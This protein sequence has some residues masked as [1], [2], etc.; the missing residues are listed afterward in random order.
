[1]LK[2]EETGEPSGEYE[3]TFPQSIKSYVAGTTVLQ[4]KTAKSMSVSHSHTAAI[5]RSGAKL[6]PIMSRASVHTGKM[7][8]LRKI[9]RL[10]N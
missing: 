1:M 7:R 6:Q 4:P 3:F 5:A 10:A 8:G 2:A 9:T